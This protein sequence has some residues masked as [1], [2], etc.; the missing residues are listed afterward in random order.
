MKKLRVGV[1]GV[2]YLGQFHAEKYARMNEVDLVGVVDI[3]KNRAKTVADKVNTK[4]YIDHKAL[5]G[6]VDAVSI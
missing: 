6:N 3:D 5:F 4:A 2:G 1:I